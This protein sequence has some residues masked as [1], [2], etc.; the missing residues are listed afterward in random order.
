[1]DPLPSERRSANQTPHT[2]LAVEESLEK[3]EPGWYGGRCGGEGLCGVRK[4]KPQNV[5]MRKAHEGAGGW[6]SEENHEK[7]RAQ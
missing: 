2:R 7:T 5:R 1:M 3:D 4:K 6:V